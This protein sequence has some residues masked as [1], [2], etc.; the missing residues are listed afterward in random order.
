LTAR[1]LF[2]RQLPACDRVAVLHAG[3]RTRAIVLR[4]EPAADNIR[5]TALSGIRWTFAPLAF[6]LRILDGLADNPLAADFADQ[7]ALRAEVATRLE[8]HL[9]LAGGLPDVHLAG[10]LSGPDEDS[11]GHVAEI[12]G[13]IAL[14]QKL[15]H[16]LATYCSG[17]G[18]L[19]TPVA[20]PH[21]VLGRPRLRE[22]PCRYCGMSVTTRDSQVPPLRL[23]RRTNWCYRCGLLSDT[24]D[25]VSGL[26]LTGAATIWPG[27]RYEY[28]LDFHGAVA[29]RWRVLHACL[30]L[31]RVPWVVRCDGPMR[32]ITAGPATPLPPTPLSLTVDTEGGK[33]PPGIYY[34]VAA[35]AAHGDLWTGRRPVVVA[36]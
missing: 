32:L 25:E 30:R 22:E 9:G 28:L 3:D 23:N 12:A 8:R 6:T 11:V 20:V 31:E 4:A 13:W 5:F 17:A 1:Q 33:V 19:N 35:V 34:L 27:V 21:A 16:F 7:R 14:N 2:I 18:T 15:D 26:T 24:S 36:E 10:N 29:P